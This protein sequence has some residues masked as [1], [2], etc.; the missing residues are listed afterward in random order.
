M[1]RNKTREF[2]EFFFEVLWAARQTLKNPKVID[3]KKN[4]FYSN[5]N[6]SP[7]NSSR[8]SKK[9]D[10]SLEQNQTQKK[11][12]PSMIQKKDLQLKLSTRK[13]SQFDIADILWNTANSFKNINIPYD[14]FCEFVKRD[15][16]KFKTQMKKFL[17]KQPI[18]DS[19]RNEIEAIYIQLE[20]MGD[21]FS[22]DYKS[23]YYFFKMNSCF[24]E[25]KV[26]D[27]NIFQQRC[28]TF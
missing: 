21:D 9:N 1:L 22:L 23:F 28:K 7:L 15:F 6:L 8:E 2:V 24:A 10:S 18:K 26:F 16:T 20:E 27:Y 12:R 13:L 11:R 25:W 17:D 19:H 14:F 3:S 4:I 5:K